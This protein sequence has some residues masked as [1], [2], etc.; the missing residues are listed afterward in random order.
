MKTKLQHRLFLGIIFFISL[1]S[2]SLGQDK[3]VVAFIDVN[4]IPMNKK[5]VLTN[6]VV[7]VEKGKIKKVGSSAKVEIPK[8][9]TIVDA[10]GKY[11][12]PALSDMHVHLEGDAWNIMYSSEDK[13]K[14]EEINFEQILFL[15]VA[16]GI[17]TIDV[18]F[19]FPEHI[20]LR[21]KINKNEMLGPRMILSRAIDGAGKA[22]PPPLTTWINNAAEA[23]SAIIDMH[24]AGYDRVK[25]YSFL[26]K[27]SYDTIIATAKSLNM[28]VDGHIPFATSP[29]Y[30][31]SSGQGMVAHLE[32]VMKF[33]DDYNAERIDY[34]SSLFAKN[35]TWIT[36]A[37]V[38]N[39][40]LNRLLKNP[41]TELHKSGTEYLHP[42]GVGI[43]DY[44]YNNVYKPIPP[45]AQQSMVDGYDLFLKPFVHELHKKGGKILI[46][47]DALVPSTMPA[48]SLHQ[49]LEELV[50]A[51]LTPFEAL[52]ISTTN[53]F[54]FLG[55]LEVAGTIEPGKNANL[56][57]LD[58]NPL[59]NISNT[60]KIFGVMT[61]SQ[62][63]SRTEIDR[64]L[65]EMK[66]SYAELKAKKTK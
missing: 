13:F 33:T 28:P 64:R 21:E 44:V 6:H 24:N 56:L 41:D 23:H 57:L 34:Y 32:E 11:M 53:T 58:E 26:D 2:I 1:A 66:N 12:I 17:T 42:M 20:P 3:N 8:G 50:D 52:K 18:L 47:T 43:W 35:D 15:Y 22:W 19:A 29:E 62:W 45:S 14:P 9:A 55:E 10:K 7:I 25:V 63:L 59:E 30:V 54:E 61:Q 48:F 51:G 38:L 49:E 31:I 36:T 60:Q 40:N 16:N 4:V 37:L 65:N 39:L 46:G 5:I 27:A